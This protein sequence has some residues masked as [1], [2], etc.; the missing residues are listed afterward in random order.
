MKQRSSQQNSSKARFALG[1]RLCLALCLALAC[2]L[3]SACYMEPDRVVDDTNALTGDG[4]SQN[5]QTVITNTPEVTNTPTPS[6]APSQDDQQVDW[7]AWNFGDDT[8]TNP[9]SNPTATNPPS[10]GTN[11]EGLV[12]N[13]PSPTPTGTGASSSTSTS[14]K[15][16]STG[17]EV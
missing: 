7:S 10:G 8:A 5:F 6:P 14:L 2:A 11:T 4:T 13:T 15:S 9:P 1:K 17:S 16:G 12:T 3:M